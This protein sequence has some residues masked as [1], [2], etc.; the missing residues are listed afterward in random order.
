MQ[1]AD[2]L[3]YGRPYRD[4]A[5]ASAAVA[6]TMARL[7]SFPALVARVDE[8]FARWRRPS[9]LLFGANDPFVD[10]RSA[11][12]FLE[13][14]VRR[15]CACRGGVRVAA[16]CVSRRCAR[17]A[18]LSAL[19]RLWLSARVVFCTRAHKCTPRCSGDDVVLCPSPSSLLP[20]KPSRALGL[21]LNPLALTRRALPFPSPRPKPSPLPPAHQHADDDHRRQGVCVCV[22]PKGDGRQTMSA[23]PA[24]SAAHAR[25]P[26]I[27]PAHRQPL[28]NPPPPQKTHHTLTPTHHPKTPPPP[29]QQTT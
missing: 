10:T 21:T 8:A 17:V 4:D 12:D 20:S 13:T 18:W 2:A 22:V 25:E 24:L 11:L 26:S 9:L 15:R 19:R 27:A 6:A 1:E 28:R 29:Q 23:P 7:D 5:A 14:K 16:V 3:A